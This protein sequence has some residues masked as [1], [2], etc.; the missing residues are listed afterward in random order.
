VY[1]FYRPLHLGPLET[2]QSVAR[3][4]LFKDAAATPLGGPVTEVVAQAKR[5]LV[6]G[7]TLDGMAGSRSTACWR[8]S[9]TARRENLRPW[10]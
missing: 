10:A 8:T 3:A 7:E 5:P 4:V 1:T 6:P 9:G 2:V